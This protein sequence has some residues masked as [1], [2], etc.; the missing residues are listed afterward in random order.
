MVREVVGNASDV[1][2]GEAAR[3]ARADDQEG[4]LLLGN[5]QEFAGATAVTAW[6]ERPANDVDQRNAAIDAAD[7]STPTRI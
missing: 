7:P 3:A 2:V 1:Q 6:P 4:L 5:G